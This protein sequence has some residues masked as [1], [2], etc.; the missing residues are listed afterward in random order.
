M[1]N[2]ELG[3][4]GTQGLLLRAV[5]RGDFVAGALVELT[6]LFTTANSNC[7]VCKLSL[8]Y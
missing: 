4:C 6:I 5:S 3:P 2:Y 7:S 8:A 1:K